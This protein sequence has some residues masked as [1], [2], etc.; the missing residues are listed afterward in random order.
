MTVRESIDTVLDAAG[1]QMDDLPATDR[2]DLA[3]ALD[4]VGRV[5]DH[6]CRLNDA[7]CVEQLDG[8]LE[9]L[10]RN[11][12]AGIVPGEQTIL[13]EQIGFGTGALTD[14]RG[15]DLAL[16]TLFLGGPRPGAPGTMAR[17]LFLAQPSDLA[18][19]VQETAKF[20][21]T[22]QRDG[23]P[24]ATELRARLAEALDDVSGG[25]S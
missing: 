5:R 15:T 18:A 1:A 21:T 4:T 2:G 22:L 13:L 14:E 7:L 3:Q 20:A 6:L 24:L 25:R 12:T 9:D 16:I 10:W 19:V 23:H 8:E 11:G 17:V